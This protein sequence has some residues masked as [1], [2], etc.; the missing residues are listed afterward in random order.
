MNLNHDDV[1]DQLQL[2]N[3][4]TAFNFIWIPCSGLGT[5]LKIDT[6][7][8]HVLGAYRTTPENQQWGDPSRTTVDHDGSVWLSN[9]ADVYNSSGS[10]IHIGLNE[11]NQCHDRN[12]N[13]V[14]DTSTG[15]DDVRSWETQDV[16]TAEDECIVHYTKVNSLG[17]RHVS[18]DA[19]NDVWVSGY[20]LQN[21]D[22]IKGG[23]FDIP[24]SGTIIRSEESVDYGGYGGLVG[25]D[26]VIWSAAPLLRW[27]PVGNLTAET[28]W[29]PPG[30]D[31]GPPAPGKF[32]S[33]QSGDSYG[34][35]IDTKS[36]HVWNTQYA[37]NLIHE[38]DK[39][40]RHL[41]AHEHGFDDYEHAQ[42]CVV[43]GNGEVWVAHSKGWGVHTIGHLRQNGSLVGN[44][45]L[46]VNL[47]N[48][49]DGY[50]PT[51]VAVDGLGKIWASNYY[52]N[53]LSRIDPTQNDGQGKVDMTV[54][55]GNGCTPYT[56]GD[57]T[58]SQNVAPPNSGTW[59]VMHNIT[60]NTSQPR[61]IE[62]HSSVPS[63]SSLD[64][65]M[66]N[67]SAAKWD[68]VTNGQVISNLTGPTLFVQVR[69]TRKAGGASPVLFDLSVAEDNPTIPD[70]TTP[71]PTTPDPK[72]PA[73]TIPDPTTPAPTKRPS[74]CIMGSSPYT[75]SS[76]S[77]KKGPVHGHSSRFS[78][79]KGYRQEH[80]MKSRW[81]GRT[82]TNQKGSGLNIFSRWYMVH[83]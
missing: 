53:S 83:V 66:K 19:K 80:H 39:D 49:T 35:C 3:K 50:G 40:G 65:Y 79:M 58:G 57:M 55:L 48:F 1:H 34:L 77:G 56:Y 18:V 75:A 8:G 37:G 10:V 52:S 25:M 16:N 14:I 23:K 63:G 24:G 70:P 67:H 47:P 38:Y 51:G 2:D 60:N 21:F 31:V 12:N 36:G 62:W 26:G 20:S 33:G 54:D 61:K 42:G 6:I 82:M 27:N 5:V 13:G 11:N 73:P 17:T 74:K 41:G 29:A 15:I 44:V 46:V 72:T 81:R 78:S 45:E 7:S 76:K 43:D 68:L 32:W 4:S 9:R 69:F 64:V 71:A 30:S 22:L 28:Y 59:T